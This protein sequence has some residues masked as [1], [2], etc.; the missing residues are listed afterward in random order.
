MP[1]ACATLVDNGGFQAGISNG[2]PYQQV[3][4]G[5]STTISDWTVGPVNIDWIHGYWEG[6][7]GST[8]DYSV[9]LS[10]SAHGSIWQVITGLV[11]GQWYNLTFDVALNP[12]LPPPSQTL[13]FTLGTE[14]GSATG[15]TNPNSSWTPY[16]FLFQWTGG[17][18]ATLLFATTVPANNCCHG[19]AL[20]N[21][22]L[23]AVPLP[24][25]LPLLAAGLGAMGYFGSRRW[26]KAALA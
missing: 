22:A 13:Q 2:S 10:G 5:D 19:P 20:D 23:N 9:D 11:T 25:A 12:D 3:N 26:R 15:T 24:A 4:F 14:T 1:A 16:S 18:S 8:A 6:S 21:V 7:S 17:V